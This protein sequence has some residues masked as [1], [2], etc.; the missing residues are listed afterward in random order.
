MIKT[1]SE[2][3]DEL[4]QGYNEEINYVYGPPGSGKT[5][6]CTLASIQLLKD[7]KKVIY[8]DTENGFSVDRFKQLTNNLKLLDNLLIVR[9]KSFNEQ[10]EKI[11]SLKKLKNISLVIIDSLGKFYR[12]EVKQNPKEMNGKLALHL[13]DLREFTKNNVPKPGKPQMYI[14]TGES[15]TMSEISKIMHNKLRIRYEPIKLPKIFWALA[16]FGRNYFPYLEKILPQFLYNPIWRASLIIDNA[17]WFETDKI[18][19]VMPNWK[20]K[21]LNSAIDDLI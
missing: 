6:L 4:I 7:N 18:S 13:N 21:T 11:N 8:I 12:E 20:P 10:V 5:T 19:K 2:I 9:I 3:L 1:G 15:L 17:L 16:K 14:L